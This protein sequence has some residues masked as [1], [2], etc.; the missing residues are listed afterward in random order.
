[1]ASGFAVSLDQ[2]K[3]VTESNRVIGEVM[4]SIPWVILLVAGQEISRSAQVFSLYCMLIPRSWHPHSIA[5]AILLSSLVK[6]G[7]TVDVSFVWMYTWQPS[8][9]SRTGS[10]KV[11]AKFLPVISHHALG[12]EALPLTPGHHPSPWHFPVITQLKYS[13]HVY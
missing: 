13:G 4:H 1:M 10:S 2:D 12:K 5:R 11:T 7:G 9:F 6:A 3:A 8:M